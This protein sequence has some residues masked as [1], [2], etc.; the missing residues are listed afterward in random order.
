M[1]VSLS[2]SVGAAI[3]GVGVPLTEAVEGEEENEVCEKEGDEKGKT[4]KDGETWGDALR[5]DADDES[6]SMT[7]AGRTEGDFEKWSVEE[8]GIDT[9]DET[10]ADDLAFVSFCCCSKLS[11]IDFHFS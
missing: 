7:S 5:A 8:D 10:E 1:A 6:C 4:A 11:R 2:V 3:A 9:D